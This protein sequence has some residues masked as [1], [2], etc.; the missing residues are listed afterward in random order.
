MST[1][2]HKRA[3]QVQNFL[4]EKGHGFEVKALPES[5]RTADQAAKAIGCKVAQIAK[6]L[7]FKD[8]IRQIPVLI[9]ASGENQVCLKKVESQAGVQLEK[10]DG[11]YVKKETGY[12]IG[13]VPP[14]A[15]KQQILTI[16]DLDLKKWDQIWAAA[17]TP[18]SVFALTVEDL[19]NLTEGTWLEIKT[20]D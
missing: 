15:H 17:G 5:T 16:L 10:A 13:G 3:Q 19:A 6:S 2:L 1:K 7:I 14:F 18:N 12:A 11:K 4:A 9:I 20:E 8:K